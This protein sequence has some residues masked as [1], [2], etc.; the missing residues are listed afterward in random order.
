[1]ACSYQPGDGFGPT[2]GEQL[3]RDPFGAPS[4]AFAPPPLTGA[5]TGVVI[6]QATMMLVLHT[7]T[8]KGKVYERLWV[9]NTSGK[10]MCV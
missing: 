9:R 7:S 6:K 10:C 5:F 2:I 4:L 3:E 1:M 8:A